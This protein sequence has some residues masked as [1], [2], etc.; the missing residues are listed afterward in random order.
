[1]N[2]AV[3]FSKAWKYGTSGAIVRQ[4][5]ENT[6]CAA[7]TLNQTYILPPLREALQL[8]KTGWESFRNYSTAKNSC[9]NWMKTGSLIFG[10]YNSKEKNTST[11]PN[12]YWAVRTNISLR[13]LECTSLCKLDLGKFLRRRFQEERIRVV[14]ILWQRILVTG[15]EFKMSFS[16]CPPLKSPVVFLFEYVLL[17]IH[18][19][20]HVPSWPHFI[21][22]ALVNNPHIV[23]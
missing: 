12:E 18:A 13:L 10:Q 23:Q 9:N 4:C 8:G 21:F 2:T 3:G 19:H 14:R 22:P 16:P 20:T 1:M 7:G 11:L 6:V 15:F 17:H 5:W